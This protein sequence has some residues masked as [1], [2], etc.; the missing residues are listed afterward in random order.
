VKSMKPFAVGAAT[1]LLAGGAFLA[2]PSLG[3][4]SSNE[5]AFSSGH[6]A[7]PSGALA[8]ASGNRIRNLQ[9]EGTVPAGKE[10][11]YHFKCP[12]KT[13]HA[14]SGFF[15]PGTPDLAGKVVL[16]DS[17]PSGK[18]NKNWDIGVFNATP[19]PQKYVVGVV[20]VD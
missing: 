9:Y 1:A 19:T 5:A 14:V 16:A 6:R 3:G 13:P 7:S 20:C 8:A 17:F 10:D 2:A 18:G 11:G 4:S 15:F 12:R